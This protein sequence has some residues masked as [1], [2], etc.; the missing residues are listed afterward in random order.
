MA[1]GVLLGTGDILA[2]QLSRPTSTWVGALSSTVVAGALVAALFLARG[3]A[4]EAV[5]VLGRRTQRLLEA[6]RS[7]SDW[8]PVVRGVTDSVLSVGVHEGAAT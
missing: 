6:A 4:T 7:T 8:D 2:A 1:L 5:G 3:P